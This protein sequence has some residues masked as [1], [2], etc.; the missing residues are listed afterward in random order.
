MTTAG[1]FVLKTEKII[2]FNK[3]AL[4]AAEIICPPGIY[5]IKIERFLYFGLINYIGNIV[6]PAEFGRIDKKIKY[7]QKLKSNCLINAK[8]E[9][10]MFLSEHINDIIVF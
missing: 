3:E 8:K 5:L 1:G 2:D 4:V 10:I 7:Q 9:F 6:G